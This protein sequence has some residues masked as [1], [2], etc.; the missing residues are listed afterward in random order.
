MILN[1]W[2]LNSRCIL[3]TAFLPFS[4]N[5]CFN[6]IF[7]IYFVYPFTDYG[8][9]YFTTLSFNLLTIFV[10][11]WFPKRC[12]LYTRTHTT[13]HYSDKKKNEIMAFVAVWMDLEIIVL[14]EVRHLLLKVKIKTTTKVTLWAS[15]TFLIIYHTS[16]DL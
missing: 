4:P 3:S 9:R 2:S 14:R 8:Y 6:I 12:G 11:G 15:I 1:C 7:Y 16:P 13:E 10:C 5:Y